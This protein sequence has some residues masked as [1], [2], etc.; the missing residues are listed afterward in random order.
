MISYFQTFAKT[1]LSIKAILT[2]TTGLTLLIPTV[3][4]TTQ[5]DPA[6]AIYLLLFFIAIDFITGIAG[7]Y[8]DWQKTD[9]K[10][11]LVSSEKLRKS[12]MKMSVYFFG[13]LCC[14]GIEKIFVVKNFKINVI[15]D[16]D[17]TISL[18]AIGFFIAVE[19]YSIVFENF[20]KMG[21]DVLVKFR[22]IFGVFKETKEITNG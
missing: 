6:K 18:V 3:A 1:A 20:K 4:I 5:I 11:R 8:V 19:F 13:I 22:K 17:F 7:S 10:T 9:R 12:G 14:W 16:N 21:F 15:S 2:K